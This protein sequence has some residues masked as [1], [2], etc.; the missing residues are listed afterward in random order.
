M[1]VRMVVESYP[2]DELLQWDKTTHI[3]SLWDEVA[4]S[5]QSPYCVVTSSH[6]MLLEFVLNGIGSCFNFVSWCG[7]F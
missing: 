3:T 2:P 7:L 6:N 1:V 5:E 4:Y